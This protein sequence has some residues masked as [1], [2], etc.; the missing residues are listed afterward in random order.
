MTR[1][2]L[3]TI[4]GA[5]RFFFF[6]FQPGQDTFLFFFRK[7]E[8]SECSVFYGPKTFKNGTIPSKSGRLASMP[9]PLFLAS[10]F[11]G[12]SAKIS[13]S[14]VS[15]GHS[16]PLLVTPLLLHMTKNLLWCVVAKEMYR[17]SKYSNIT[18]F[19]ILLHHCRMIEIH[20]YVLTYRRIVWLYQ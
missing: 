19:D 11:P 14:E 17:E 13:R 15:G 16:A 1:E 20:N 7:I 10:F 18:C 6:F 2:Y 3:K 9:F 4:D 12:R 8:K 5:V